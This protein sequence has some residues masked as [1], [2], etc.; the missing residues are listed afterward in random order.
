MQEANSVRPAAFKA[1]VGKGH[2]EFSSGRQQ[3]CTLDCSRLALLFWMSS[4]AG[5][6]NTPTSPGSWC[7]TGLC[8]CTSMRRCVSIGSDALEAMHL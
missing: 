3:V 4:P 1:L 6:F 5:V 2:P 7:C 8:C